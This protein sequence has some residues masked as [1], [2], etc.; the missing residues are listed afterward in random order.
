MNQ[1][2]K[3]EIGDI[4]GLRRITRLW[5]NENDRNSL[6]VDTVCI[7]CGKNSKMRARSVMNEKTNSCS[8][9]NV[10]YHDGCGVKSRLYHIWANMKYRCNTET[11]DAYFRYG[12]SG[13]G[14]CDEWNDFE[15]FKEWALSHGY[16]DNLTIDRINTNGNYCPENCQWITKADNTAKANKVSQHRKANN[17]D[18][19]AIAPDGSLVIF[20]N[21][22]KFG[23]DNNIDGSRIRYCAKSGNTYNGWKFGYISLVVA[24]AVSTIESIADIIREEASRVHLLVEAHGTIG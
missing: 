21:A 8:C 10:K 22:A 16:K 11:C 2:Y 9:M 4:H 18:Y 23:R 3:Y 12:G 7:N 1:K 15:R 6:W 20:E 13:I 24:E 19:Y 17:G 14:V 5:R